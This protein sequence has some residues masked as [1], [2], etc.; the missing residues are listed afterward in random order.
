MKTSRYQIPIVIIILSFS[1][2]LCAVD[3]LGLPS[4][5]PDLVITQKGETAPGVFIGYLGAN[6]VDYYVVLDQSGYP[7]FYSRTDRISYPG[8]MFNGLICSITDKGYTLKD[9]SF[10]V[11]DLFE[12]VGDYSADIHD[13]KVMPNGHAF[14]LGTSSVKIDMS[15]IV[16]GGRPDAQLTENVIQEIDAN[17]N[18]VFEWHALDH[19]PITD[20]FYNL[21]A[22]NIDYAHFNSVNIDPIDNNLLISFRTTGE[23]T[24][25]N[26][27][28]GE[29]IWRF[30]GKGNQFTFIGEHEENA[31]YYFVGQHCI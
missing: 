29:I 30:G 5:F 2:V 16:S 28:T 25:V 18:V 12:L 21:T 31:P 13:F 11:V 3:S 19:I 10:T 23:I 26:R 17:K 15:K 6:N 8:V 7:L 14:L 24:K 20:S 4:D 1:S 9:E 27:T 22:Q